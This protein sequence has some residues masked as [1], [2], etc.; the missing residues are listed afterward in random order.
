MR[1]QLTTALVA[2]VLGLAACGS[3]GGGNAASGESDRDAA[4]EFAQCMRENGVDM[5]DPGTGGKQM[6]KVGPGEETT[7]EEMEKAQKACEK[8][9]RELEP[10]EISE[11]DR[12]RFRERALEHA[13]C[14]REHGI[15]FPDPR[16]DE[17]GTIEVEIGDG[18]DPRDPAVRRAENACRQFGPGRAGAPGMVAP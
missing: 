17:D 5:P 10:A 6:L 7:P 1:T 3:D 15:D 2:G 4:L 14:M 18:F 9:Q 13:R 11:E 16:F 8:Y 12:K